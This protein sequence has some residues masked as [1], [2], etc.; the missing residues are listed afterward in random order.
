MVFINTFC[1]F[2]SSAFCSR[3]FSCYAFGGKYEDGLSFFFCSII[4][5]LSATTGR[6][7]QQQ[8]NGC[9]WTKKRQHI[10]MKQTQFYSVTVGTKQKNAKQFQRFEA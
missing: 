8:K 1:S 7:Q 6:L 4:D 2:S 3:T 10:K 5:H 9:N